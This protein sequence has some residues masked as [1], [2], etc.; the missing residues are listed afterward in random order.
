MNLQAVQAHT[1]WRNASNIINNNN[2]LIA[3][4]LTKLDN[5]V[6]KNKGYFASIDSLNAAIPKPSVGS[7]AYVGTTYPYA[8]YVESNGTWID[9]GMTGGD[10][11]VTFGDLQKVQDELTEHREMLETLDMQ[12][13]DAI[14]KTPQALTEAQQKQACSNIG[15][16]RMVVLTDAQYTQ[17]ETSGQVD[18]ETVYLITE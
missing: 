10:E 5:S 18:S 14:L 6:Y 13:E 1:T 15:V 2:A 17:L 8:I 16:K 11:T 12:A 4:E 9:S 3:E 7:K